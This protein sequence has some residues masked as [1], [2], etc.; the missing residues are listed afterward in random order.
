MGGLIRSL[1]YSSVA[2]A[3]SCN[4]ICASVSM[5]TCSYTSRE[6]NVQLP[7]RVCNY[8]VTTAQTYSTVSKQTME[9]Y[10]WLMLACT[11]GA[12]KEKLRLAQL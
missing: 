1:I 10:V 8:N 9:A 7:H 5:A 6:V 12:L 2:N 3:I 4:Y 11:T